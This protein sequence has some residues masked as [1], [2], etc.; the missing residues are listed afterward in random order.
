MSISNT[1][2]GLNATN[3]AII[4]GDRIAGR[5]GASVAIIGMCLPAFFFMTVAG[6]LYGQGTR[7]RY[8][9]RFRASP[10]QPSASS[11]RRGLRSAKN[12]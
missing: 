2:P 6:M 4:V 10:P 12:R 8:R 11:P 7:G 9:Q 5:V 1:L 3:M